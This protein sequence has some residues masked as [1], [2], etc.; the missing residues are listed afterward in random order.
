MASLARRR[1]NGVDALLSHYPYDGDH[2]QQ[3]RYEA[4]RLRDTGLP[5]LHGHTHQSEQ[6]TR[7][8]LTGAPQIHVGWDSWH[9][10]VTADQ[11]AALM[12]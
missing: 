8:M 1:I 2:T 3:T 11:I 9:Q 7:S 5:L 10:L 6:I 12:A 4:Y